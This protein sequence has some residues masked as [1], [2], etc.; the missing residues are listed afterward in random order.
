MKIFPK[1]SQ[2]F[3]KPTNPQVT[4]R[5]ARFA[6]CAQVQA[7]GLH[8]GGVPAPRTPPRKTDFHLGYIC[9][10]LRNRC[11]CVTDVDPNPVPL[12]IVILGL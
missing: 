9:M 10:L 11:C 1:F 8:P 4:P 2:N 7:F 3:P 12:D 6:R 5:C